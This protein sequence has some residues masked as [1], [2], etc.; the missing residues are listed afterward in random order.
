MLFLFNRNTVLLVI[1]GLAGSLLASCSKSEMRQAPQEL[2]IRPLTEA[3]TK[4]DP[5]LKGVTL[6]TDNTYL[7]YASASSDNHPSL[8][9]GNMYSY[10]DGTWHASSAPG[11]ASPVYWPVGGEEFDF[12]AYACKPAAHTALA[13]VWNT[14]SSA[15][16]FTISGWDTYAN[17][18]DVM[19]AVANGQ[20]SSTNSGTVDMVFKHTMAVLRFNFSCTLANIYNIQGIRINDLDYA[21]NLKVDNS[22]TE[23]SAVWTATGTGDKQVFCTDDATSNLLDFAVG[24]TPVQCAADFLVIPQIVKKLTVFYKINGCDVVFECD[25]TLPRTS[26]KMGYCYTYSL[27]FD[28]DQ[29]YVDV[30]TDIDAWDGSTPEID[31]EEPVTP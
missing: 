6:G 25:V 20:T 10:V 12:L 24:T 21:G 15:L 27:R 31:I 26:W 29:M 14:T 8:L 9:A 16:D 5:E 23:V 11:T 28:P 7:I 13:P 1:A 2:T 30:A 19:Y 22:R 3:V 18:Y 4:A 17:Q